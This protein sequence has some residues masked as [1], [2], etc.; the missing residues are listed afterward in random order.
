MKLTPLK[1]YV[2]LKQTEP[3]ETTTSGII[4]PGQ[5][6]EKPQYAT[7]VAVGPNVDNISVNNKVIYS[8]YTGIP[9]KSK[10]DTCI[11]VKS[12][13]ILAVVND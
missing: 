13:D 9:V 11:I 6:A 8:K 5:T 10:E 2:I 12:S 4:L 1:N 7:V 3:E